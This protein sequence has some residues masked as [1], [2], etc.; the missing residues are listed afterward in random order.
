M[1]PMIAA[2]IA[3]LLVVLSM[4]FTGEL[5]SAQ[6]LDQSLQYCLYNNYGARQ[7]CYSTATAC[8][9]A[10][11]RRRGAQCFAEQRSSPDSG[12]GGLGRGLDQSLQYCLYNNYGTRVSCYMTATACTR[13]AESR[14][15]AQC[16]AER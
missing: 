13:A 5:A 3:G 9:D 15:G 11:A 6:R 12:Y 4:A 8:W 7:L 16:Y 10:A 14:R 2:M 1:R